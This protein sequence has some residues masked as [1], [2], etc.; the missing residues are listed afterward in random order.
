MN[1]N[2][3]K[4]TVSHEPKESLLEKC[5]LMTLKSYYIKGLKVENSCCKRLLYL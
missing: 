1:N 3:F 4:E 5:W 2:V